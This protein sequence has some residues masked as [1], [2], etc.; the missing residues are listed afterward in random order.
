MSAERP[1]GGTAEAPS[2]RRRRILARVLFS[3]APDVLGLLVAQGRVSLEAMEAFARWS[4]GGREQ[5][6]AE[7]DRLEHEADDARRALLGALRSALVTPIDQEDLYV[8]SERCDR[9]V[10][11]AKSITS[12]ASA[13][14]WTPDAHACSMADHLRAAMGHTLDGFMVLR[15]RPDSAGAA[16]DGVVAEARAVE[17]GYR[18]AMVELLVGSGP[19]ELVRARELYGAYARCGE[20][21]V[22]VADRLWYAVLAQR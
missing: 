6:A 22:A 10:N 7:V 15:T 20:L 3:V 19:V 13:L 17:H 9:V 12:T 5:D 1:P 4:D 11:E 18:A 21:V 16:A 14:S 8:L 2:P